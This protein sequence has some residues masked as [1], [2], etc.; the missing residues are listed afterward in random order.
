[1]KVAPTIA[2]L[3]A[4]LAR[5][6]DAAGGRVA[7]VPT[8]GALHEGHLRL[9]DH[10]RAAADRV[11]LSIFVNP[12]QFGPGEDLQRYPRPLDEDTRRA[13]ARGVDLLFVPAVT[14]LYPRGEPR[15]RIDAGPMATVLCGASRPGHFAGVLTVVAKLCHIVQ[16]DV[17]VFGRKDYQQAVLVRRMV[18]DLDFPVRIDVAPTLRDPDGLA[19][20]SRNA[21]L[22]PPE[23]DRALSLFRGLSA[24]ADAFRAGEADPSALRAIVLKELLGAR[25]EPDYAELVD[26]EGLGP[27]DAARDGTVLAVAGY[28]G[29][30][31]LIDNIVLE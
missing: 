24:A 3:R 9:V 23:R 31:R 20:S 18:Q 16:P 10:A 22:S 27:V 13:A 2:E 19:L 30:T 29:S 4:D 28:V 1:V 25:V 26:P 15:V 21:Y 7:L 14:E 5:F 6:R 11:V 8:M 12:L 17:A